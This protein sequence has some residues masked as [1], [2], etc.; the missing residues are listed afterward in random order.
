V[1]IKP[2]IYYSWEVILFLAG[3]IKMLSVDHAAE[4]RKYLEK[5]LESVAKGNIDDAVE[6]FYEAAAA[7]DRA[8]YSKLIPALWEAIAR[9]LEPDFKE[10]YSKYIEAFQ[11]GKIQDVYDEWYQFPLVYRVDVAQKSE[12]RKYK[13]PMHRQAW[14][15]EWAAKHMERLTKY[16]AAYALYFRAAEKAEQTRAGESSPWPAELYCKAAINFIRAYGG[17][18][19]GRHT[20][21]L[22]KGAPDEELIKDG[23]KKMETFYL[24][25]NDR[26][27]AY[28]LLAISY[29]LL[30]SALIEAGNMAQADQFA[31]KERSALMRYYFHN[32][33]YFRAAAEWLSGDGFGY[34]IIGVFLMIFFVFPYI[35]YHWNLIASRLG[36]IT[37]FDA[38]NYSIESA[39]GIGHDEFYA[40]GYGKILSIIEAALAWLGLGVFIWW[41]TRRLE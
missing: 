36:N 32:R 7:F 4:G 2:F 1:I 27:R 21:R 10:K 16:D 8:Q 31:R 40:V 41:L 28:R 15:Y 12:W 11:S 13:D 25:I 9:M 6:C 19:V 17:L 39:L 30:K 18:E 33:S 14:A 5:G 26:R 3:F 23:I 24:R 34:F 20:Q 38:I 22:K 29:R 35:Y 37:F